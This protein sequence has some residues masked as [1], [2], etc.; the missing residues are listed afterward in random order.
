ML[1]NA[2]KHLGIKAL[3]ITCERIF[4]GV[5]EMNE[6]HRY[7]EYLLKQLELMVDLEKSYIENSTNAFTSF[8][9]E[10]INGINKS[11]KKLMEA[12]K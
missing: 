11:I 8:T 12:S 6:N 5:V 10:E 2:Q 7:L 9:R 1:I 3:I 4:A